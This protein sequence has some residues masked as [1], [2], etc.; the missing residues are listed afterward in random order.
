M[1]GVGRRRGGMGL[2]DICI[3]RFSFFILVDVF[4]AFFPSLLILVLASFSP[5]PSLIVLIHILV[6]PEL[7]LV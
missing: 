5:D 3:A 7:A 1:V 6:Q 4:I 2:L